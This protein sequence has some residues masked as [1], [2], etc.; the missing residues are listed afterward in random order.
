RNQPVS[1]T[2]P[3]TERGKRPIT[4]DDETVDVLRAHR[5]GQLITKVELEEVYEDRGFVF[6]DPLGHLMNPDV[7][8]GAW[9][10]LCKK[11]GLNGIR[12]HDLRHFHASWLLRAGMNPKVVQER[13]GHSTIAIT[14]DT[15]SHVVPGLQEEA[16]TAFA[17]EMRKYRKRG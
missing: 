2:P 9:R 4:L 1:L 16:A 14:L 15:Y 8:T 12:L 5:G 6:P 17:E 13:L 3:K 10:Q 7:V 11:A